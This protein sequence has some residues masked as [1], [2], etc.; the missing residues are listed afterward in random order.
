MSESSGW[1]LRMGQQSASFRP[2][3]VSLVVGWTRVRALS[4][5][6]SLFTCNASGGTLTLRLCSAVGGGGAGACWGMVLIVGKH[7]VKG[8]SIL[9]LNLLPLSIIM[10]CRLPM[11]GPWARR[12]VVWSI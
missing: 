1:F 10:R 3:G 8:R 4:L 5:A 7:R 9:H 12:L 2:W 11:I 6:S